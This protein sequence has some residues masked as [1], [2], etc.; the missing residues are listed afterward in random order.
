MADQDTPE[1]NPARWNKL[2]SLLSMDVVL[3]F[4]DQMGLKLPVQASVGGPRLLQQLLRHEIIEGRRLYARH[5]RSPAP[6]EVLS[7]VAST[8]GHQAISHLSWWGRRVFSDDPSKDHISLDRW[9]PIVSFCARDAELW[10]QLELSLWAHREH[11]VE[12]LRVDD[13]RKLQADVDRQPLSDWDLHLYALELYDDALYESDF[14]QVRD[15]PRLWIRPTVRAYRQYLFWAP[16]LRAMTSEQQQRLWE[17]GRTIARE[18]ELLAKPELLPE[19]RE[20]EIFA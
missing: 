18:E 3:P 17:Q 20:L 7:H 1:A 12:S 11:F 10:T 8:L 6:A 15:G 19:P 9:R 16:V 13:Y 2:I 5:G 14:G 4:F